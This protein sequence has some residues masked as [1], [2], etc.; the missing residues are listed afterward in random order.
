MAL[1]LHE[2]TSHPT[3]HPFYSRTIKAWGGRPARPAFTRNSNGCL[4]WDGAVNS[5]GY[6]ITGTGLVH[7]LAWDAI[8]G[9][10]PAGHDIHHLCRNKLCARI[11][12]LACLTHDEHTF[13]ERRP[14]KLTEELVREILRLFER[15]VPQTI[16]ARDFGIDR[17]YVSRINRG[18]AWAHVVRA[19]RLEPRPARVMEELPIAA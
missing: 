12:H 5:K 4:E 15:G 11:D 6:P 16:I 14:R 2:Q 3:N 7:R 17:S 9:P 1:T 10:I 18:E 13:L 8:N 19:F